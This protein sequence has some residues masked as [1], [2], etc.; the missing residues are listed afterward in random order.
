[1]NNPKHIIP[2]EGTYNYGHVMAMLEIQQN[3]VPQE[4]KSAYGSYY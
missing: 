4:Q 3:H 1:M 2:S